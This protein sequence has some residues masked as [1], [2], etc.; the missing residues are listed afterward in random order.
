LVLH[1]LILIAYLLSLVGLVG[2]YARQAE[3]AGILGLIAFL[4]TF[5]CIAPRFAWNWIE[6]FIWPILAQAAPRLLDHPEL[7]P[8]ALN[9]FG[10][11]DF[12]SV[13][14][15]SV[16]VLL[17]GIAS[18]RARVLPRWAAVLVIVGAVLD[19]V[20]IF[21]GVDFP[22]A[23]AVSGPGLA[24]MGYAVWSHKQT[25]SESIAPLTAGGPSLTSH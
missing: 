17:F 20:S 9:V 24:W 14:L 1:V 5:L 6:A 22:F 16:G 12:S 13:L 21:V 15:L 2:L 25:T 11:V 3:K 7:A 23:A 8:P 18:L 19:L 4:L 10:T